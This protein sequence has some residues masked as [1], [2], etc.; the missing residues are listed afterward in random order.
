MVN[1]KKDP[2]KEKVD[3]VLSQLA[4]EREEQM[5]EIFNF[6][7]NNQPRKEEKPQNALSLWGKPKK[8]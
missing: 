7:K 6:K 1:K 5:N 4:P 8:K 3:S 2:I